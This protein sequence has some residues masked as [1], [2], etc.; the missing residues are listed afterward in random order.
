MVK[1]K[2][3]LF[4]GYPGAGKT[5]VARFVAAAT[6]A[7][8]LWADAERHK[9]FKRPT[10][11]ERESLELYDRLNRRTGELLAGGQSVVYDTN[12]NFYRDRQKLRH[13][14]AKSGAETV[15]VWITVPKKVARYRAVHG[16]E[17]R[18]GYECSMSEEQFESI[19]SKLEPPRD[20]ENFIKISGL[21]LD[22]EEVLKLLNL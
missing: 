21:K 12:F 22:K 1:P 9:L 15:L 17:V 13:I 11:S 14:A 6:G 18:N 16:P 8:H 19:T 7:V 10:H 20:N 2:L 4:I 3:Y 5:T